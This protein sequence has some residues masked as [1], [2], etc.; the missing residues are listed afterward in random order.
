MYK[1]AQNGQLILRTLSYSHS[2]ACLPRGS[3]F[4]TF[5]FTSLYNYL[6]VKNV[7]CYSKFCLGAKVFESCSVLE[8]IYFRLCVVFFVVVL[9]KKK[10]GR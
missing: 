8:H 7:K 6:T 1:T 9:K 3:N 2:I 4:V 5:F 10:H